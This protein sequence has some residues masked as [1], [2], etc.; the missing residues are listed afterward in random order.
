VIATPHGPPGRGAVSSAPKR[1]LTRRTG[2]DIS[3]DL[4]LLVAYIV[5]YSFGF[6]GQEVHEWLSLALATVML[7]HLSLH[8]DWVLRATS[9]LWRRGGRR[10][11]VWLVDLLL[12]ITMTLCVLSGV[13]VS[14]FA[15]PALGVHLTPG[16]NWNHVHD[17]TAQLTLALVA[18]H[19]ALSWQWILRVGRQVVSRFTAPGEP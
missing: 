10:R 2:L 3:L 12:L 16:S 1:R 4:A 14:Q 6:T 5:A 13:L 8:W 9:R 15:L 17:V 11:A 18:T 19:V 7:L